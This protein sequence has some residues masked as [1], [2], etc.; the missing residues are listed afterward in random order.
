MQRKLKLIVGPIVII[1]TLA[2]FVWYAQKNPAV[3]DQLRETSPATIVVVMALY[4]GSF[5][6][7][8]AV[9]VFSLALFGKR[10][11][12]QENLLLNAYSSLVN[13]FGPGQSGP[14]V[15]AVYLKVR[16]GLGI[17]QYAFATLV[18]YA[19][20]AIFSGFF[21]LATSRPWWQT[22]LFVLFVAGG[23]AFVIRRFLRRNRKIAA[24][25]TT[26][27]GFVKLIL[28]VGLAT[29]AQLLFITLVYFVEL[30]ALH[31][32]ISAGQA[33]AYTG[34]A[35][36]ALFVS[37]TPGAIGF[38]EAFLVF[39]QDLHGISNQLI[40][41]ANVIDRA[42]YILFLG[43]LLLVVLCLHAGKKLQLTKV[44]QAAETTDA[45]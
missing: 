10:M 6:A 30:R 44:K 41:A 7:L 38:R 31:A 35:N 20:F 27:S 3:I 21:L 1:A 16:H 2:A 45:Q 9:L 29:L 34:A 28:A 25:A 33:L 8:M 18:Y 23:C 17:K 12:V 43:V 15:R 42:V 37:L 11:G 13:F 26:S 36:F 22:L 39:S 40:V 32:D 24:T 5:V 19:F 14:G 4:F